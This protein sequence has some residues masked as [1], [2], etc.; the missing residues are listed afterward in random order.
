MRDVTKAFDKVWHSGLK[1]KL[2]QIHLPDIL[3][4]TLCTFLDNR[5]AN[6]SIGADLS[7]DINISSGVPQG[8]VLSPTLYTLFTN[9]LPPPG[10]GCLDTLYADDIT[11]IVTT[12]SKSKRMM[13]LKLEREIQRI[14]RFEKK[15]KIRTSEEKFKIIPIAQYKT[16]QITI[17]GNNMNINKDGKFLGLKLQSTG[18]IGHVTDK[19]KKAKGTLTNLRRFINLTTKLKTTLVKALL[20]P[21]IEYPPVPLCAISKAQKINLQKQLNKGLRFIHYNEPDLLTMEQLHQQYNIL[22]FNISIHNKALQIWQKVRIIEDEEIFQE[23]VREREKSH[24]WFPKTSQII[25]LPLPVPI[26]T[27]KT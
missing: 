5:V 17:N 13:K 12:P 20:I 10:P 27:S 25:N 24:C 3:L 11:Q 9:D 14:N 15:W 26:Y 6:I 16:E 22:P 21:V 7:A 8:S 23:L 4:K 19:I 18:L 2:M 1:Y